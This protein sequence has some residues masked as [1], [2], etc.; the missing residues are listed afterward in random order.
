MVIL[1][2]QSFEGNIIHYNRGTSIMDNES[3]IM[4]HNYIRLVT[5]ETEFKNTTV[6]FTAETQKF[7]LK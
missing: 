6:L 5:V 1:A 7:S 3:I 2:D 4:R